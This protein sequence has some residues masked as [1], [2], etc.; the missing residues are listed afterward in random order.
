MA[1]DTFGLDPEF[2]K[3]V[4]IGLDVVGSKSASAKQQ[5]LAMEGA[6]ETVAKTGAKVAEL[7]IIDTD[8]AKEVLK[9]TK[10]LEKKMIALG[11]PLKEIIKAKQ[12]SRELI[13]AELIDMS[14]LTAAGKKRVKEELKLLN[15]KEKYIKIGDKTVKVSSQEVASTGKVLS[16]FK[17]KGKRLAQYATS[18]GGIQLSLAGIVA[19]IIQAVDKSNRLGGM[20]M[21]IAEQWGKSKGNMG[22]ASSEIGKISGSFKKMLA[23]SGPYVIS[24]ARAGFEKKQL[25]NLSRELMSVEFR[26]GQSVQEQAGYIKGL[27]AN[28]GLAD[29]E[30][31]N[32]LETVRQASKTIPM[33]SMSEAT[34][35]W[36]ELIDKTKVFNTDL[37]GTLSLYNA[38]MR[39]DI[40]DEIGL[41]DAPRVIRKEIVSTVAGFSK[42]LEDGWKAALGRGTTAAGKM[43]EFENLLKPEQFERMAK[44]ITEKTQG[45]AGAQREIATR[46]IL[47]KMGFAKEA[48]VELARAF[49]SGGFDTS[50]LKNMMEALGKNRDTMEDVQKKAAKDRDKLMQ[51]GMEIADLLSGLLHDLQVWLEKFIIQLG[52]LIKSIYELIASL[53]STPGRIRKKAISMS[54]GA[55]GPDRETYKKLKKEG[56]YEK[57]KER[58]F[59]TPTGKRKLEETKKSVKGGVDPFSI[60]YGMEQKKEQLL[61]GLLTGAESGAKSFGVTKAD[62]KKTLESIGTQREYAAL[63]KLEKW[64]TEFERLKKTINIPGPKSGF[65]AVGTKTKSAGNF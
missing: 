23:E 48:R 33:L 46:K 2:I 13:G 63:Q 37:L 55:F 21:Q 35:D 60:M 7:R 9:A 54:E 30:A 62:F 51:K 20:S 36:A 5:I 44:F 29:L 32:Y 1:D 4:G 41:G 18:M 45:F 56:S 26:T 59:E 34:Q 12:K 31:A 6:L 61:P 15:T 42:D 24:L 3:N 10:E 57:I 53:P 65:E 28:F 11:K 19:L 39:K 38:L 64:L 40:A 27:I 8:Q 17:E 52:A 58:I 25:I 16:A 43:I 47:E 49:A 50:G 14:K 22:A